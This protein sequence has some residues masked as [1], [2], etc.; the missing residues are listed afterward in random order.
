MIWQK[1]PYVLQ[2]RADLILLQNYNGFIE[3]LS[4]LHWSNHVDGKLLPFFVLFT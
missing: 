3:L 4:S 1:M 2:S